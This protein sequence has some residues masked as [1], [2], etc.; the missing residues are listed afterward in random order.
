[1]LLLVP[2]MEL[3]TVSVAVIVWLPAVLRVALKD[4]ERLLWGL[5]MGRTAWPSLLVKWTVRVSPVCVLLIWSWAVTVKLKAL[6]AVAVAGALT[7]KWVAV[8]A[9]TLMALLVPVML[10]V[11]VSVA[12]SV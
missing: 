2:V 9:L 11:T 8:A 3:V 1:M 10:L 6:P 5:R 7:V 12:V 4:R